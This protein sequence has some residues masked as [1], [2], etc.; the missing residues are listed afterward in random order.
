MLPL[1]MIAPWCLFSPSL[2]MPQ[3]FVVTAEFNSSTTLRIGFD[4]D[5]GE[6][7][8]LNRCPLAVFW[9]LEAPGTAPACWRTLSNS[10][11]TGPGG[12]E[13]QFLLKD[14]E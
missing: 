3:D 7:T 10:K 5:C 11:G 14:D 4:V 9:Q 12:R 13:H 2:A 6:Q 1:L 8:A